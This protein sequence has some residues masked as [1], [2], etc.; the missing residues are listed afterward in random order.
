M[1]SWLSTMV[2]RGDTLMM[3]CWLHLIRSMIFPHWTYIDIRIWTWQT[4]NS[5]DIIA[6]M[7][8]GTKRTWMS[9]IRGGTYY[10]KISFSKISCPTRRYRTP[11]TRTFWTILV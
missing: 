9:T 11:S 7:R 10:Y 6:L 1:T 3:R 2:I 5:I 8:R 4:Y